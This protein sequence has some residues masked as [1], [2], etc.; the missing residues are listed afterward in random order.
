LIFYKIKRL[1]CGPFNSALITNEGE[2][3][4]QG[5]NDCGQLAFGNEIG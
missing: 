5:M 4:I 1:I 3:L 2:I